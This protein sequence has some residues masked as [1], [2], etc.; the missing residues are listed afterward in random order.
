MGRENN[1]SSVLFAHGRSQAS[2]VLQNTQISLRNLLSSS[3]H[4]FTADLSLSACFIALFSGLYPFVEHSAPFPNIPPK[5]MIAV[6]SKPSS[7]NIAGL[8]W[9]CD[10]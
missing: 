6:L 8:G 5:D 9:G 4:T 7:G 10:A 1:E 3:K 2:S